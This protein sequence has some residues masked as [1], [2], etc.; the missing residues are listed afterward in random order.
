MRKKNSRSRGEMLISRQWSASLVKNSLLARLPT[1]SIER[2]L[3][4]FFFLLFFEEALR[5]WSCLPTSSAITGM[6]VLHLLQWFPSRPLS[7]SRPRSHL[8]VAA[9]AKKSALPPD[10]ALK[11]GWVLKILRVGSLFAEGEQKKREAIDG[12]LEGDEMEM[13]VNGDDRCVDCGCACGD[14]ETTAE[15]DRE[16]FSRLLRRASL[17]ETRLY[18]KMSYLGSLAYCIPRIKVLFFFFFFIP[19][20]PQQVKICDLLISS[21]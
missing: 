6:D 3:S 15:F 19:V 16:S 17:M 1:V 7:L 4:L 12:A 11:G 9:A 13:D 21:H 8:P 2:L 10:G 5:C 18:A 14:E 20:D